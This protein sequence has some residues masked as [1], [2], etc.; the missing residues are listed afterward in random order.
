MNHVQFYFTAYLDTNIQ[1]CTVI[2]VVHHV[3]GQVYASNVYN[4]TDQPYSITESALVE[5]VQQASQ[6]V[7]YALQCTRD[8]TIL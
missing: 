1:H 5:A 2:R 4:Y 7:D 3:G 8:M 6:A